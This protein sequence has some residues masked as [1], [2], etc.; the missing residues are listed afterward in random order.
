MLDDTEL[1]HF[2]L[3][4]PKCKESFTINVKDHIVDILYIIETGL[5]EAYMMTGYL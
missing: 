2:P 5:S 4:C 1:K 3:F